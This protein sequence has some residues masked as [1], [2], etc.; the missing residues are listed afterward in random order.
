MIRTY[1]AEK[2]HLVRVWVEAPPPPPE[3]D[4]KQERALFLVRSNLLGGRP[5]PKQAMAVA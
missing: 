1:W 4:N 3:P 5:I 2:G